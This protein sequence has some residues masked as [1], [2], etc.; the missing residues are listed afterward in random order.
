[1][2]ILLIGCQERNNLSEKNSDNQIIDAN[3]PQY[4]LIDFEISKLSH[5]IH[6]EVQLDDRWDD[7]V[8]L[9]ES[10]L[11]LLGL[12][13]KSVDSYLVKIDDDLQDL[14]EGTFP[15]VFD[16]QAI[17]SRLALVRAFN[18][19]S[20][21]YIEQGDSDSTTVALEQFFIAYNAFI[22]R[23]ESTHLEVTRTTKDSLLFH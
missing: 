21:F 2:M 10:V 23:I 22:N 7:L 9:E 17:R 13:S 16:T 20:T 8:D 19:K 14:Q 5:Q 6:D 1:M 18:Q 12:D 15:E 4:D 3:A 11:D